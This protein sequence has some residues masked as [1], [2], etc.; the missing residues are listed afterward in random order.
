MA[1]LAIVLALLLVQMVLPAINSMLGTQLGLSF[2]PQFILVLLAIALFTGVFAGSFPA[3]Y[4]S[5]IRPVTIIKGQFSIRSIFKSKKKGKTVTSGKGPSLRKILVVSQFALSILFVIC[6]VAIQQQLNFIRNR[7]LGFDKE[8]VLVVE[9]MGELKQRNQ[10]VKNELLRFSEIQGVTFGAFSPLDWES[11]ASTISMSWTG[12]TTELEFGIGENYVDYDYAHTLGLELVQGR[13][14]SQDF[15]A[16]ALEGCVVNETAV[17]AMGMQ[18]PIGKKITWHPGT[19]RESSRTIVGVVRNFNT[20]S[21][22]REIKPFVLLPIEPVSQWMSNFMYIKI[23]SENIAQTIGLIGTKIR[24]LVPNDPFVHYFLDE[25]MK[26]LYSAEQ[27]TGN[28]TR[29]VSFLAIFISCLGLLAL[30]SFSVERRTKEIGIRKVLGSSVSQIIFML[31]KDFTKRVLL[32]NIFAWPLAYFV[33]TKWL[34]NFAY[35]IGIQW[36][37]FL[38]AGA[39]ALVIAVIVV[40]YQTIRAATANPVK[41]LRYE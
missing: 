33:L 14:L 37:I 36:W 29:Y 6:V 1:I 15:P 32:A 18:E 22:H 3:F 38:L 17:M 11:S 16:D 30:A 39:M 24:E 40:S 4:L 20:Q 10:V 12:K 28:L 5:A 31:T 41:A 7:N 23:G 2:T 19:E 27:L 13:F 8:H 9:S 34:E 25:E 35:R 26:K 21:L